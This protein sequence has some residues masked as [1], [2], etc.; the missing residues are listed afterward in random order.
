MISKG[1]YEGPGKWFHVD[2][3]KQ[4][5]GSKWPVSQACSELREAADL[6]VYCYKTNLPQTFPKPSPNPP[7]TFPSLRT[8]LVTWWSRC[9]GKA[10]AVVC[11]PRGSAEAP[12]RDPRRALGGGCPCLGCE[13]QPRVSGE[14]LGRTWVGERLGERGQRGAR[15]AG[16]EGRGG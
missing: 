8:L 3:C 11:G 14:Q 6:A 16:S 9:P 5:H 12:R 7:Q 4:H 2:T 1:S 15:A 13:L 10:R